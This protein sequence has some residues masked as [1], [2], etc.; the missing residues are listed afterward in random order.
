VAVME[1]EGQCFPK[2]KYRTISFNVDRPSMT[3][4]TTTTTTTRTTMMAYYH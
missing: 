3:V 4:T 2:G 1:Q